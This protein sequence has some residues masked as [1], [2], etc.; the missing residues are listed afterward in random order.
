MFSDIINST[1]ATRN[2][3]GEVTQARYT[4]FGKER[5]TAGLSEPA[6]VA[7]GSFTVGI[8]RLGGVM[9]IATGSVDVAQW[10]FVRVVAGPALPLGKRLF[11]YIYKE[12][13]QSV[14]ILLFTLGLFF[15][16]GLWPGLPIG[17]LALSAGFIVRAGQLYDVR[18]EMTPDPYFT[19]RVPDQDV[20]NLPLKK[21]PKWPTDTEVV[22]VPTEAGVEFGVIGGFY[23]TLD[24][25]EWD[26]ELEV[27]PKSRVTHVTLRQNGE[28]ILSRRGLGRPK[29][30]FDLTEATSTD[31]HL[32]GDGR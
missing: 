30:A 32:T 20:R 22:F 27:D 24:P 3:A 6:T 8:W 1:A 13:S 14:L 15:R 17:V 7:D 28:E 26:I 19:V 2:E 29:G 5:G 12:S 21:Y 18:K 10:R 9:A 16:V 25:K 31:Q 11:D 4:P 23:G